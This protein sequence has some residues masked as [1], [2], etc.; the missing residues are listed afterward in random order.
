M[1]NG[2]GSVSAPFVNVSSYSQGSYQYQN[3]PPYTKPH[4]RKD[5]VNFKCFSLTF[6]PRTTSVS[7]NYT[8]YLFK[9]QDAFSTFSSDSGNVHDFSEGY[10]R[11][12][13]PKSK[14]MPDYSESSDA[15]SSLPG[16]G[17]AREWA[18]SSRNKY[19]KPPELTD[20]GVSVVSDTLSNHSTHNK[21]R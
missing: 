8:I 6:A 11:V 10:D 18:G 20:S 9:F 2:G 7:L 15:Y 13:L 12:L 21:Q 17:R 5:K 16:H 4:S 19:R 3:R 14:S 1:V